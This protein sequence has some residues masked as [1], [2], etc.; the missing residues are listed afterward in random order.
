[1]ESLNLLRKMVPALQKRKAPIKTA[2]EIFNELIAKDCCQA[3]VQAM[4][5]Y[6]KK[7]L[8]HQANIMPKILYDR[9]SIDVYNNEDATPK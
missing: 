9:F 3:F 6:S 4:S 2:P 7:T 1:M 8:E 5:A